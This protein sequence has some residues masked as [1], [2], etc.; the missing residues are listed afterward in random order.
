MEHKTFYKAGKKKVKITTA[1][2]WFS[3]FIRIRDI[4]Y[5]K[6]IVCP[7]CGMPFYW[8][9]SDCGHY[10]TRDKP[11]TRFNEQNCHAQCQSCNR[12]RGG[13]QSLH[14]KFIDYKYGAGTSDMLIALSKIRGQKRHTDLALKDIAKEYRLKAKAMAKEK[15]ITL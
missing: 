8:K 15:G 11:M 1:D 6:T 3:K 2:N 10:M 14:G 5:G 13:E 7:T 12:F 4:V 9:D